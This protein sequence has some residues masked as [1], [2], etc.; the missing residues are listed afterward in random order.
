M[1]NFNPELLRQIRGH[2]LMLLPL[3]ATVDTR[4]GKLVLDVMNSARCRSTLL[5]DIYRLTRALV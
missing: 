5:R 1:H 2:Q 3:P 4:P